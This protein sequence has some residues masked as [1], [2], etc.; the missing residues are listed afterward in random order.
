MTGTKMRPIA[1]TIPVAEARRIIAETVQPITRTERVPLAEAFGRVLARDVV[2]TGDVP[3]FSRAAMDGYAV[4]AADTAGAT[5]DT[6]R[7]LTCLGQVFTGEVSPQVVGPGQCLEIATG[8]P[9]PTGADAVIMVEETFR[10]GSAAGSTVRLFA[11]AQ[12]RQHIGRQGA[13]IQAGTT[14]LRAG[15]VLHAG[16]LGAIA[17]VGYADV[18]VFARPR[19]T[20]LS[21]GNEVVEPG[22]PLA[23]GQIHDINRFTLAGVVADNGGLARPLRSARDTIDDLE[24]ALAECADDELILFSGGSSVGERDLI[25]DVL[26]ARGQLLFHGLAVKPGKPTA[27]GLV[28]GTPFF[29]MPGSPASCLSNGYI[30]VAPALRRMARLPDRAWRRMSLPLAHRVVSAV[31]RHQFYTV[32]VVDGTAVP[33]FKGSGDITSMSLADGYFE[34]AADVDTVEAGTPVEVTLFQDRL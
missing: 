33:A 23:P 14:V 4:R 18:E 3:P 19:V 30:L 5:R 29:G 2:A 9:L 34:I 6:P 27:F 26:Q 10:E 22:Q 20:I 12:P 11:A 16:R 1:T 17:A 15:D 25:L 24:R 21:T 28:H 32:R 31:G 7:T 8:A 13:D